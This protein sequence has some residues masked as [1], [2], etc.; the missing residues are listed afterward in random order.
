MPDVAKYLQRVSFLM[1][2]GQPANDVAVYLPNDDGWAHMNPGNPHLIEVLRERV[3]PDLMPSIFETGYN[4]DFFDDDSFKQVG[5]VE[6]GAL[7]LGQNKYKI[8]I[9]PNV[10]TI[11]LEIYGSL[12]SLQ[13]SGGMLI[14]TRQM[15]AGHPGSSPP[16]RIQRR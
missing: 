7:V 6:N 8:V 1:R 15:P 5:R 3:G 16:T 13:E 4:L 2:Q 14:A 10:E 11:P 9:L 12:K